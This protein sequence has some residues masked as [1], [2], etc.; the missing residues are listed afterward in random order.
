MGLVASD[1]EGGGGTL[2]VCG[3]LG[4]WTTGE[5]AGAEKFRVAAGPVGGARRAAGPRGGVFATGEGAGSWGATTAA[6]VGGTA[7]GFEF[8]GGGGASRAVADDDD[9]GMA[10]APPVWRDGVGSRSRSRSRSRCSRCSRSL[11]CG[12]ERARME[13]GGCG[14]DLP[15]A[16]R[17]VMADE[18]PESRGGDARL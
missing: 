3:C 9:D 7:A 15:E 12:R 13:E 14:D 11:D 4:G 2:G 16:D 8:E 1:R 6:A 5:P 17:D 18:M 10:E